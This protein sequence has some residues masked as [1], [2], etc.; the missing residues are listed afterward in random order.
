MK[1][2]RFY[3]VLVTVLLL[4]ACDNDDDNSATVNPCGLN[5]VID[6]DQYNQPSP[7][8]Y[9]ISNVQVNEGCLEI[10]IS[11]SGCDGS[12]WVA[13][14]FS[15]PPITNGYDSNSSLSLKLTNI[16]LCEAVITKTYS[17]NLSSIANDDTHWTFNL[18]GWQDLIE[19]SE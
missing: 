2:I 6:I 4:V 10:T 7:S 19:Y 12:T 13:N 1:N 14:L 18:E 3:I 5:T 11:G 17:F 15:T 16:E 9:F 8:A